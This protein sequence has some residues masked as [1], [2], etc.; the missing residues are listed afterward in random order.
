MGDSA[1]DIAAR[2]SGRAAVALIVLAA[3][4]A[5]ALIDGINR[6]SVTAGYHHHDY[7]NLLADIRAPL[8]IFGITYSAARQAFMAL[9]D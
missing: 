1:S 7:V 6:T 5:S 3:F 4:I 9:V 8:P 2:P